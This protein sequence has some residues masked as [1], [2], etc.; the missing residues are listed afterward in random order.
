[1]KISD[2]EM[3]NLDITRNEFHPEWTYAISPR[4]LRAI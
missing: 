4:S 2:Q 1:V 3:Q